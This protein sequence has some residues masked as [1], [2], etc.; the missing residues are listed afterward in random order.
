MGFIRLY[1]ALGVVFLHAGAFRDVSLISGFA[2]VPVFF[3]ISG[4]YM[5]LALNNKY[6]SYGFFIKNRII[7]LYP[8]Y[9]LLVVACCV[10]DRGGIFVKLFEAN[11]ISLPSF[12]LL[13]FY[14]F[15]GIGSELISI[16]TLTAQGHLELV[17]WNRPADLEA[18]NLLY[19]G[20]VW[21]LSVEFIFYL[22]A[23]FIV[24]RGKWY[25]LRIGAFLAVGILYR[26]W[27][28]NTN[29][30]T[31]P[32]S[33]NLFPAAILFFGLG[34]I[35]YSLHG[36]Y[37]QFKEKLRYQ[38]WVKTFEWTIFI[39]VLCYMFFY[40]SISLQ[41]KMWILVALVCIFIS[42]IFSL[43]QRNKIDVFLGDLSYP[44]YVSH[45]LFARYW[46]IP[47]VQHPVFPTLIASIVLVF[48]VVRP[49]QKYKAKINIK[50]KQ[51]ASFTKNESALL[52][53]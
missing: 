33:Y 15:V 27:L 12:L 41:Y 9:L 43:T 51:Q 22:I 25:P 10:T 13:I 2:A 21:S 50:Q 7:K 53:T 46:L 6:V 3:V 19:I 17:S 16:S 48:T 18:W 32:W 44:I 36:L 40:N 8:L 29:H 23:P 34:S 52:S 42:P 5:S 37:G 11:K 49:L 30:L 45:F 1:L 28:Y 20:P 39:L 24:T 26:V 35:S 14:N 31:M 38:K 4:F 47:N